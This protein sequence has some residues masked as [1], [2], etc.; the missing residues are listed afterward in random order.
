MRQ[1]TTA[2]AKGAP[3]ELARAVLVNVEG[4]QVLCSGAT[5]RVLP[6]VVAAPALEHSASTEASVDKRL[7]N[8]SP[9]DLD[10]R[11]RI[12]FLPARR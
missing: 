11:N 7:R 5:D 1:R 4:P 10:G 2:P 12:I 6:I 9:L 3:N 8:R